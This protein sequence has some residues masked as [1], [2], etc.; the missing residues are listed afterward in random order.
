MDWKNLKFLGAGAA[1]AAATV[2]AGGSPAWAAGAG[3]TTGGSSTISGNADP[4]FPLCLPATGALITLSNTGTFNGGLTPVATTATFTASSG[5]F[6]GPTGTF[7][8]PTCTTPLAVPGDLSVTGGGGC[9]S[10]TNGATYQRVTNAYVIQA[11]SG[12]CAGLVYTGNQSP[13]LPLPVNSCGPNGQQEFA[14]TYTQ[15]P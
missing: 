9:T 4:T 3:V 6:F 13:C 7:S 1:I 11:T 15:T 10:G 2:L 8:D 14:G 12:S 5:F